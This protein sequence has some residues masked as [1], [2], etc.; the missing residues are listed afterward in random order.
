MLIPKRPLVEEGPDAHWGFC[1]SVGSDRGLG[2]P[3]SPCPR[4]CPLLPNEVGWRPTNHPG[5]KSQLLLVLAVDELPGPLRSPFQ[6]NLPLRRLAESVHW[7]PQ[8]GSRH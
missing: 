3:P 5:F 4:W 1:A 6:M 2:Y 7:S 8:H